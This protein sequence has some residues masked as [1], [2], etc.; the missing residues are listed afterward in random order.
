M[1]ALCRI[2]AI[3]VIVCTVPAG[4]G[5]SSSSSSGDG[6][7]GG[8]AEISAVFPTGSD[9]AI[10]WNKLAVDPLSRTV[11]AGAVNQLFQLDEN[12]TVVARQRT[13]PVLDN[14]KCYSNFDSNPCLDAAS[15]NLSAGVTDNHNR[16][17]AVDAG[18]NQLVTCGSVFQGTCQTRSLSNISNSTSYAWQ[19]SQYVIVASRTSPTVAF[20]GPGP[21]DDD[22]LYVGTS[23]DGTSNTDWLLT[24]LLA[25]VSGRNL[26]HPGPFLVTEFDD[27]QAYGTRAYL[28]RDA[29]S[30]YRVTYVTGFSLAGFSYFLTTQPDQ[31]SFAATSSSGVLA[32]KLIQ[33]CQRDRYFDSYVEMR[34]VCLGPDGADYNLVQA[35]TVVIRPGVRLAAALNVTAGDR[36]LVAA[37]STSNQTGFGSALCVYPL[38]TIRKKFTENIQRCY[39][40]PSLSVGPQ[41]YGQNR[42]C[43]AYAVWAT[44]PIIQ[45]ICYC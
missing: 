38:S 29:A 30:K 34:I 20:V 13:G 5:S 39:D 14:P 3:A 6:A 17:L 10:T 9:D 35:A 44:F 45:Y 4:G 22:V 15:G 26:T 31:F 27:T 21:F 8:K 1:E 25:G 23:Y 32:S 36:V 24:K 12:L 42:P 40:S 28:T 11:Y 43:S 37:F 2:F 16:I 18:H 19:F 33:V 41:F 7:T